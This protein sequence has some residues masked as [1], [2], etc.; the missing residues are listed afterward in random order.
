MKPWKTLDR[1]PTPDGGEYLLQEHDGTFVIRVDGKELMSSRTHGSEQAM[2]QAAFPMGPPPDARVLIGGLGLGFT[3]R[4]VLDVLP[5]HG[6]VVVGEL[7]EAVLRWNREQLAP[8]AGRPL[9]DLRAHVELG[10]VRSLMRKAKPRFHAVLLDV[11]NGP[12]AMTAQDNAS[13]Y[14]E[15]G[16]V[17][18]Y[19]ALRPGGTLVVWSAGPDARYLERLERCGFEA[20]ARTVASR[21]EG[22]RRHV[23][24]LATRPVNPELSGGGKGRKRRGGR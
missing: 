24:F 18:C 11:D 2:A 4:A 22:G 23:L 17:T 1:A 5:P 21:G 13:L 3:L 6:S 14:D 7:S 12:S 8:L 19:E 16:I 20:R 10:D 9:E 15:A